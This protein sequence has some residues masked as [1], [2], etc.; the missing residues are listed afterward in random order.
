MEDNYKTEKVL[1]DGVFGFVGYNLLE[2]QPALDKL[3]LEDKVIFCTKFLNQLFLT[4]NYLFDTNLVH[5]DIKP[6]NIIYNPVSDNFTLIDYGGACYS[7]CDT[8]AGSLGYLSPYLYN[9]WLHKSRGGHSFEYY[10]ASDLYA[11]GVVAFEILNGRKPYRSVNKVLDFKTGPHW[12]VDI[13]NVTLVELINKL[14]T[15]K[16]TIKDIPYN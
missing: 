9:A 6:A 5:R 3:S 11:V 7:Q 10:Q 14:L 13:Q 8:M 2:Y 1:G 16:F 4:L 12:V 15:G